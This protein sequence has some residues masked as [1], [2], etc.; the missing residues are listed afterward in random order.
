MRSDESL[1]HS[2]AS[3]RLVFSRFAWRVVPRNYLLLACHLTNATAQITQGARF[4]V[5]STLD[6][7]PDTLLIK[8]SKPKLELPLYGR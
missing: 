4:V 1:A 5:G 6:E 3:L 8:S 2:F 7:Q